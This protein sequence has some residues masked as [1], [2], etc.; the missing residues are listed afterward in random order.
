M[1]VVVLLVVV[2]VVVVVVLVVVLLLVVE[3]LSRSC[4]RESQR[5]LESVHSVQR[6]GEGSVGYG[7]VH[8]Q[9]EYGTVLTLESVHSVQRNT[10][11]VTGDGVRLEAVLPGECGGGVR[12]SEC[13]EV[14]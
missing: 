2:L 12:M 1:V 3:Y 6:N 10:S 7:A 8:R 4:S 14:M 5:T 11:S 9:Y 13:C